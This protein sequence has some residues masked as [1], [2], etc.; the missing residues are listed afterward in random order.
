MYFGT[1]LCIRVCHP[2]KIYLLTIIYAGMMWM[3]LLKNSLHF[4]HTVTDIF[5]LSFLPMGWDQILNL[6]LHLQAY[7][8][9]VGV[10]SGSYST[11]ASIL[12]PPYTSSWTA[13]ASLPRELYR[14]DASIVSGRIRVAGGREAGNTVYREEVMCC[15]FSCAEYFVTKIIGQ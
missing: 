6:R 9:A 13:I 1:W 4:L 5:A 7:I 3:A 8:V 11:S 10:V 2:N 15:H 12:L 14:A